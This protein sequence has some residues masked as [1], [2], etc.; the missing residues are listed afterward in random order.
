MSNR[1]LKTKLNI[2]PIL[3]LN[4]LLYHYSA[5]LTKIPLYFL[6]PLPKTI[7]LLNVSV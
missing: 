2:Q 6:Y 4:N 7:M 1:Y 5:I 3:L